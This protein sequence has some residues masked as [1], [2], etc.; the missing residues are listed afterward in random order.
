MKRSI[1]CIKP[2]E[3]IDGKRGHYVESWL[4]PEDFSDDEMSFFEELCHNGIL[5]PVES[6]QTVRSLR[7]TTVPNATSL[8]GQYTIDSTR[9]I[10]TKTINP[11]GGK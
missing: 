5:T 2:Y 7:T 4:V 1:Y 11:L 3:T 8:E 6:V 10:N 9:T